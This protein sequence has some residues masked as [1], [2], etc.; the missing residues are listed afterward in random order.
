MLITPLKHILLRK[1]YFEIMSSQDDVICKY[2]GNIYEM[3][4]YKWCKP[5]RINNLRQNFK[6]WTSGNEKID[7]FIQN[8][9]LKINVF[10]DIIVE[11]IPY[12]QFDNIKEINRS[13][14]DILYSAIWMDDPLEYNYIKKTRKR[15]DNRKIALKYFINSQNITNEF[16]DEV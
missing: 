5:C 14:S 4:S 3:I 2:C 6:N 15:K 12:N 16:F 9:Q 8:M 7:D 10:S 11:W 13:C 1:K